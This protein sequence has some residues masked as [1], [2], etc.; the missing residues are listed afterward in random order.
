MTADRVVTYYRK[1][2]EDD[3]SSIDQQREWAQA[4]CAKEGIEIVRQFADQA[5]KGHET[6]TR[7]DFHEMLKFCQQQARQGTPID[8]LVCWHPNRFSRSDSQETGWFIWEF[9]KAGVERMLTASNGWID[10]SRMEDRVLFNITQDTTNH[11]YVMDLARDALRGRLDAAREGRPN[12]GSV[13][14][15]YRVEYRDVSVRGR[16]KRRPE[17]LVLGPPPEVEIVRYLFHTYANTDATL[18]GLALELNRRGVPSPKGAPYWGQGTI[19]KLLN[20]R[21]YLGELDWGKRRSGKFFAVVDCQITARKG[22]RREEKTDPAQWVKG[23][24]RHDAIIDPDT[25]E[26]VQA[27]LA[28]NR[29]RKRPVPG[30]PFVLS[31]LLVCGHCQR[32]MIGRTVKPRKGRPRTYRVYICGGYNVYGKHLC[33][34]NSVDEAALLSALVAKLQARFLNPETLGLLRE[35]IRRQD[36]AA[37]AVPLA[38]WERLRERVADLERKLTRGVERLLSVD[39]ALVA[40]CREQLRQWQ[41]QRDEAVTELDRLDA[42]RPDP[43]DLEAGVDA[44]VA[45]MHRLQEALRDEDGP[46][47]RAVLA[48]ALDRVEL[49]F[50]H[51]EA[52]DGVRCRFVRG[53]AY[54]RDDVAAIH[55]KS[56]HSSRSRSV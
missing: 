14:Y 48:E 29:N 37:L 22:P 21:V 52:G 27:K 39:D 33:R 6:A 10:F 24:R 1:S 50:D 34:R 43:D 23:A 36:M 18:R 20:N 25:F 42:V 26:R 35:E 17:R 55:D 51:R 38:E 41:Q 28:A 40:G 44:A 16:K 30:N 15:G 45:L 31:G 49:F 8:G 2:N 46:E 9:R 7:T 53:L 5:K 56:V 54:L 13:P 3:G 32:G 11:R 4:A 12:G 47:L 19:K